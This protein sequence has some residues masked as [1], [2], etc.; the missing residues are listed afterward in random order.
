MNFHSNGHK[1]SIERNIVTPTWQQFPSATKGPRRRIRRPFG[2]GCS[3]PFCANTNT[4]VA[5]S[6]EKSLRSLDN[7]DVEG[8]QKR[9]LVNR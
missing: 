8:Y 2:L 1:R 3:D 7:G 6:L 9:A 5:V 4:L